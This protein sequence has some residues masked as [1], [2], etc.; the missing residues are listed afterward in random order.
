MPGEVGSDSF[1]KEMTAWITGESTKDALDNI[2]QSWPSLLTEA[3]QPPA[4]TRRPGA[5]PAAARTAPRP[6]PVD[7]R[8]TQSPPVHRSAP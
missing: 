2:E 8:R 3:D 6:R 5:G 1:W 4:A 7:R